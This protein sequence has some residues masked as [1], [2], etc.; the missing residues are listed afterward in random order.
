[1]EPKLAKLCMSQLAFRG[2]DPIGGFNMFAQSHQAPPLGVLEVFP[3]QHTSPINDILD[4]HCANHNPLGQYI[5]ISC[6]PIPIL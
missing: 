6:C 5:G 1:M 2:R 3:P 4:G